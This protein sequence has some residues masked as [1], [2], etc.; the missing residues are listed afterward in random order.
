MLNLCLTLSR[1]GQLFGGDLNALVKTAKDAERAGVDTVV[2]TD[3]VVI[4]TNVEK[5]PY[6]N[7]TF[8]PEEPWPEP[9]T[10]LAAMAATTDRIRL[11]T[12]ILIASCRPAVLLAKTIATL[13]TI[14]AGRVD[15][16]LGTGWQREEIEACGV[17]MTGRTARLEDTIAVCRALWT[18]GPVSVDTETVTFSDLW[19]YP[20]PAQSSVP[21]WLAGPA[22]PQVLGRIARIADGWLPMPSH[23]SA[24]ELP[25]YMDRYREMLVDAGRDPSDAKARVNLGVQRNAANEADLART[26]EIGLPPLVKAGVTHA[27]LSLGNFVSSVDGIEPFFADLSRRWPEANG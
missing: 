16:G 4:G 7:F 25:Q 26:L 17:P 3:H 23:A 22:S 2:V 12:G 21:I 24:D 20:T 8:P 14:S 19:S 15:L 10:L 13:D 27:S 6:G 5:Y 9:L 11:A 18:G 1:V